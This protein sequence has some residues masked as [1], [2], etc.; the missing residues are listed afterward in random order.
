MERRLQTLFT[1]KCPRCGAVGRAWW[2][3]CEVRDDVRCRECNERFGYRGRVVPVGAAK[4][5]AK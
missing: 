2:A 1:V 5:K 4:G 3:G